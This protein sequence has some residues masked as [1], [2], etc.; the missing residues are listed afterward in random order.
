VTLRT[1]SLWLATALASALLAVPSIRAANSAAG[2]SDGASPPPAKLLV[3]AARIYTAAPDGA[4]VPSFLAPGAMLIVDGKITEIA[5]SIDKPADAQLVD[6]GESVVMPGIVDASTTLAG[7]APFL[8]D[9][10]SF[11]GIVWKDEAVSPQFDPSDSFDPFADWSNT[12]LRG[13]TTVYLGC[14]D[15]RLV[16]GQGAIAKLASREGKATIVARQTALEVN[17]GASSLAPPPK[18]EPTIPPTIR[19]SRP[20]SSSR[21]RG[22]DSCSACARRSRRRR[23]RRDRPRTWRREHSPRRSASA[24]RCA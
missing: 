8:S 22:S 17:L 4:K 2:A 6:L 16:S 11:S 23:R 10:G 21:A 12:L 1:S 15:R 18:I 24:V 7:T 14:G 9:R 5:S 20:S 3:R 13:V 19:S